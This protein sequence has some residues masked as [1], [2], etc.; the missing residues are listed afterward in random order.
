MPLVIHNCWPKNVVCEAGALKKI[1]EIIQGLGKKRVIIFTDETMRDFPMIT[2]TK[3]ELEEQGFV[4]SIFADIGPNPTTVMVHKAVDFMKEAQPEV[5]LA[6]GGG[7]PID[8]AKA[9]NVVYTHGGHVTEYDIAIG[10]IMKIT[11]KL[12]PFIAVPTT[13]G[14]GTEVT[15]VGVITNEEKQV[16]FGVLSPLLIPDYAVLDPEVTVSMPPKLTA[17]TGIDALTH[18][19]ESYVSK[20]QF[21]PAD[22]LGIHA[23]KM[24]ARNLRTA[25]YDGKNLQARQEMLVASMMAGT[26]FSLNGLGVCHAMAHQLSAFFNAPHGMANAMLLPT[27]MRFNLEAQT[28]RFAHI[29]EALGIDTR[30]LS[31]AQAAEKAVEWVE[32]LAEEFEV[33]KYLDD[34]GATKDKI[35]A[36]VERA[37][38]DNPITTNP[39]PCSP[40]DVAKLYESCFR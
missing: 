9:A 32:K 10:G 35:P 1:G 21:P 26:A 23:V 16:K 15:Y 17:F 39:R 36:L 24:I 38:M 19:I 34:I 12:L 22:A 33:P 30:G 7:S 13:A 37:M 40:E 14:T 27:A 6:I 29:A 8:A 18:A 28:E 3:K 20:V 11:P 25:Y 2:G 4:V 31:T 5:I